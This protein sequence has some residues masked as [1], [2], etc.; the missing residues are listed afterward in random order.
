M[1]RIIISMLADCVRA[2]ANDVDRCLDEVA[3][4]LSAYLHCRFPEVVAAP[5]PCDAAM[6]GSVRAA[7][8]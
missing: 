4:V 8:E 5:P 1:V 3:Y 6:F 2:D 7:A